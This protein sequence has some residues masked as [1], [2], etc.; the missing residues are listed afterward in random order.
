MVSASAKVC[1][2]FFAMAAAKDVMSAEGIMKML[3]ADKDGKMSLAEAKA[4]AGMDHVMGGKEE[5]MTGPEDAFRKADTDKSDDVDMEELK[6][7]L[8][9]EPMSLVQELRG[10][11]LSGGPYVLGAAVIIAAAISARQLRA[12]RDHRRAPPVL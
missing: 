7:F 2:L 11:T 9:A 12:T 8:A 10:K 1:V 3:D 4:R 5:E 6:A